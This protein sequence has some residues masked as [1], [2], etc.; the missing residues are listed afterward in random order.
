MNDIKI[1]EVLLFTSIVTLPFFNV[2]GFLF[3]LPVSLYVNAACIIFVMVRVF[4]GN[5][6]IKSSFNIFDLLIFIYLVWCAISLGVTFADGSLIVYIKT[7]F[8]FFM[9][10]SLK[11]II[12]LIDEDR[13]Y[14]VV[15]WS[16][17][18]GCL[19][20]LAFILYLYAASDVSI[21]TSKFNYWNFTYQLFSQSDYLFSNAEDFS[22]SH[23]MRNAVGEVFAFYFVC[24]VVACKRHMICLWGRFLAFLFAALMFSRRAVFLILTMTVFS[25]TKTSKNKVI[26]SVL[27]VFV[28][29]VFSM[30]DLNLENNSNRLM[31]LE[32]EERILMY[33]KSLSD[34]NDAILFGYGYGKKLDDKYYIHNMVLS[35]FYM[36]GVLGGL[37]SLLIIFM[38]VRRV[39]FDLIFNKDDKGFILAIPIMGAMVGS[40]VEGMFTVTGWVA[41]ALYFSIQKQNAIAADVN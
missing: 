14:V 27:L 8:Y 34:I 39:Y 16:V 40:T 37:L 25:K 29:S 18:F 22:S 32:S 23:L 3:G 38:L 36:T 6:V 33:A 10:L 17:M 5:K 26:Y 19:L 31:N 28:F 1:S 15:S 35:S 9:Y 24:L 4:L 20:Y 41:L 2:R 12:T 30:S 7:L 21:V 11:N 13:L